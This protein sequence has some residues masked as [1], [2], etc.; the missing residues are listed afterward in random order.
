MSDEDQAR[1]DFY[2]LIARLMLA[3]PNAALLAA[4]A[5]AEPIAA[6][7][8]DEAGRTLQDAWL[9]LT[10]AASVMDADAVAEEFDALFISTGN[11][12]L[13]PYGSFYLSGHLN[14]FPLA[15]LRQD[16]ARLRLA[17]ARGVGE[18]EDHLGSLCETMRVLIAGAPG[19]A[20]QPLAEQK[21]LFVAHVQPWYAACLADIA[22]AEPAN[23][24]RVAAAF[25]GAFL[26]VEA[27][28]FAVWEPADAP[29]A[30]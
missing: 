1:A 4:L 13:N 8:V 29:L 2:A 24:Y 28:A 15:A 21:Q 11:P 17:R 7:G 25:A 27:H 23:F 6:D 3:P 9:K 16:L 12:L 30:A 20:R 5:A 14:D 18:F 10:Q 19:I 26:A 22:G